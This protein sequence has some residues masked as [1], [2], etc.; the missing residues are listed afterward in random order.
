MRFPL[1]LLLLPVALPACRF[2][3]YH[4]FVGPDSHL[5]KRIEQKVL[6]LRFAR[7]G[8]LI[9]TVSWLRRCGEAAYPRLL[10]AL[11]DDQASVRA[12]AA[13]VLGSS[14]DR[15]LVPYLHRHRDDPDASVHYEV[16]RGLA[17]LGDWS[18][19]ETLIAGLKDESPYVRALCHETLCQVTRLDFGFAPPAPETERGPAVG[20]WE[21]WW[22]RRRM[23]PFFGG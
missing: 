3:K 9:D 5:E 20:R 19:L 22:E 11:S 8:E 1:P 15:R 6:G 21:S 14:R 13:L 18:S 12:A 17:K 16:A 7:G 4:E 10:D 23:D 2:G